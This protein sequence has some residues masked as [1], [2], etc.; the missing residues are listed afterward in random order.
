LV[1]EILKS[2]DYDIKNTVFSFI[3]NTSE[4][5]FYG[6]IKGIEDYLTTIQHQKI[7]NERETLSSE[8]IMDIISER[9]RVEK[10]AIK[11]AKLRTFITQDKGRDDLVGHVY[12]ITYGTIRKGM[13]TWL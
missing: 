12:D 3:P 8:E 5:A 11:D 9:P 4:S 6:M 1:P 7:V 10:V 13:I 2:I